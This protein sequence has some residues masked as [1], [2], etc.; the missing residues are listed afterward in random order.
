MLSPPPIDGGQYPSSKALLEAC[1]RF[2]LSEGYVVNCRS[3]EESRGVIRLK[4]DRRTRASSRSTGKQVRQRASN[5]C[6]CPFGIVGRRNRAGQWRITKIIA[7]HNHPGAEHLLGL[8]TA[9]ERP[10]D[11]E[12]DSKEIGESVERKSSGS[13]ATVI[14][15]SSYVSHKQT[16]NPEHTSSSP[17]LARVSATDREPADALFSQLRRAYDSS[18]PHTQAALAL[19]ISDIIKN[20]SKYVARIQ[21]PT[22]VRAS[23]SKTIGFMN[24]SSIDNIFS[25]LCDHSRIEI[26]ESNQ[27]RS[28]SASPPPLRR[29]SPSTLRTSRRRCNA[30]AH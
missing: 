16:E 19:N 14:R 25:T 21:S 18:A 8:A 10:I 23:R 11:V 2:G 15:Q 9:V 28:R 12:E 26:L 24:R 30:E 13:T 4:C 3:T 7:E 29:C 20:P 27:Q 1:Q 5:N 17:S 6:D 22:F